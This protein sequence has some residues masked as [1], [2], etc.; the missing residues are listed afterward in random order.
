METTRQSVSHLQLYTCLALV[1]KST[2]DIMYLTMQNCC[3]I[4]LGNTIF[5]SNGRTHACIFKH[6]SKYLEAIG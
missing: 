3:G 4:L 2:D 6:V 5:I 1:D